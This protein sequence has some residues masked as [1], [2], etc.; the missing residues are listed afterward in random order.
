MS[1]VSSL[2]KVFKKLKASKKLFKPQDVLNKLSTISPEFVIGVQQEVDDF[3]QHLSSKISEEELRYKH[4]TDFLIELPS[5]ATEIKNLTSLNQIFGI[6]LQGE[7]QCYGCDRQF[8]SEAYYTQRISHLKFL[9][10]QKIR[11]RDGIAKVQLLEYGSTEIIKF[12]DMKCLPAEMVNVPSLINTIELKGVSKDMRN[13]K[14]MKNCLVALQNS[15]AQLFVIDCEFK[16]CNAFPSFCASLL[17]VK[18]LMSMEEMAQQV[19]D[20]VEYCPSVT[21]IRPGMRVF[22]VYV[23]NYYKFYVIPCSEAGNRQD[24][25]RRTRD[26]GKTAPPI[27]NSPKLDHIVLSMPQNSNEYTRCVIKGIVPCRLAAMVEYLEHGFTECVI[28]SD[29]KCLPNS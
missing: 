6:I 23:E 4:L 3:L 8:T 9:K 11:A 18:T 15:R 14:E 20:K 5:L 7:K 17:D 21:E 12:N 26:Y 10:M 16:E 25:I 22:I 19:M 27:K 13:S 1:V 29:M 28:F 2:C 24:L